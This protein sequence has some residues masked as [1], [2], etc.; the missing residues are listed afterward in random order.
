MQLGRNC[1]ESFSKRDGAWI[2]QPLID[3]H[4]KMQ[5][6]TG[7][8]GINAVVGPGRAMSMNTCTGTGDLYTSQTPMDSAHDPFCLLRYQISDDAT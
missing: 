7:I 2:Y 5:R 6:H 4:I 8:I 1:Q 3:G